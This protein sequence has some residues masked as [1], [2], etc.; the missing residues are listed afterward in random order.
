MTQSPGLRGGC[1]GWGCH[2]CGYTSN[3]RLF[4]PQ[5]NPEE[6]TILEFAQLIKNLVGK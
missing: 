5:G 6:H 4:L 2:H 3:Q 1:L